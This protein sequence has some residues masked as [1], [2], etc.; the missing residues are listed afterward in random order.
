MIGIVVVSHGKI[1]EE[2]VATVKKIL[3]DADHIQ[4]VSVDSDA[5]SEKTC[6]K[7]QDAV[8]KVKQEDG[9]LIL[10]DMFGGTP[11]NM[12]LAFLDVGN[13]DVISG[14]NLPMLIKLASLKEKKPLP[15]LVKFITQ[16]G[17]NHI[18][19]A[20]ELLTKGRGKEK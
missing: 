15:E 13:V 14:V 5:P 16:Y 9:V 6:K 11:T 4:A 2:M 20:G 17:Q 3:P 10:S 18:V 1:A 19:A 7:I 12:C 8:S